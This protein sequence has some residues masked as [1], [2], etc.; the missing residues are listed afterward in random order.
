L[1]RIHKDPFAAEG[2]PV[3]KEYVLRTTVK[4]HKVIEIFTAL[5]DA[6]KEQLGIRKK[7]ISMKPDIYDSDYLVEL[8]KRI[9]P[10]LHDLV[11]KKQPSNVSKGGRQPK[12]STNR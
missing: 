7:L 1:G 6:R 2:R 8:R 9:G 3:I 12:K 4:A 5:M 11:F 10:H